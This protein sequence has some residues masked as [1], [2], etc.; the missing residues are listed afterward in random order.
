[1][2]T[3]PRLVSRPIVYTSRPARWVGLLGALGA[4]TVHED[5][6]WHVLAL[7]SG[8]VAVHAVDRGDRLDGTHQLGFESPDLRTTAETLGLDVT[9]TDD[10]PMVRVAG[11]DGLTFLIGE[12]TAPV[13]AG[14]VASPTEPTAVLP[15]WYTP[16]VAGA[17]AVLSRIG[18]EP[19][20]SS[21]TATWIDLV[22]PGGGLAAAHAA[23]E[24]S[25]Q[26]SFEHPDVGALG[27]RAR[28]AGLDATVVDE[29]YGQSLRIPDPDDPVSEVW[30]NQTQTDLYGYSRAAGR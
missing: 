15:L 20:I 23:E 7:G 9:A 4:H 18:L 13:G 22:A 5:G 24:P 25:V 21:D 10:G 1:M 26:V 14:A 30:V 27:R 11:A 19:R 6:D 8:R 17:A 29:S 28:T 16:D 3:A 12:V 2:T